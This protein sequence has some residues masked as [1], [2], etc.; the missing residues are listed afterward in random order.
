MPYSAGSYE[1]TA[2]ECVR[3]ATTTRDP[4]LKRGL[5][6][7]RQISLQ[8]AKRLREDAPAGNA[9]GMPQQANALAKQ[10]LKLRWIGMEEEAIELQLAIRSL[11]PDQRG[12]VL[13]GPFSTD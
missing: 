13:V 5:Q 11:P 6:R 8:T 10:L 12:T 9:I 4:I 3:L 7:V 1:R 2:E